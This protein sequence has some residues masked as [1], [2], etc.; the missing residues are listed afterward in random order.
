MRKSDRELLMVVVP[1]SVSFFSIILSIA[2]YP[3]SKPKLPYPI[4]AKPYSSVID[5]EKI[6][7]RPGSEIRYRCIQ[8]E[9]HLHNPDRYGLDG[10]VKG[11]IWYQI[12]NDAVYMTCFMM[13]AFCTVKK[14]VPG[15][16]RV[17]SNKTT[18]R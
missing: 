2:A 15:F 18:T 5:C 1:I 3:R 11:R 17:L 8:E 10:E 13:D 14:V 7:C 6:D 9:Y 4:T 16:Y 12:N